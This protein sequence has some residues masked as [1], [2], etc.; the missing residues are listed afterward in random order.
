[1]ART[2]QRDRV[3]AATL[4]AELERLLADQQ[5][6]QRAK[7]IS[8]RMKNESGAAGVA[9]EIDRMLGAVTRS[10]LAPV[11]IHRKKR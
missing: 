8:Q 6:S 5:V 9:V 3:S 4:A 2:L 7:A 1:V 11:R 10:P